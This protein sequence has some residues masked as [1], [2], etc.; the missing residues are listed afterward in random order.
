MHTLRICKIL[1]LA[2]TTWIFFIIFLDNHWDRVIEKQREAESLKDPKELIELSVK[3]L[4][5]EEVQRELKKIEVNNNEILKSH[6]YEKFNVQKRFE[7]IQKLIEINQELV[8]NQ[9]I[10]MLKI[11]SPSDSLIRVNNDGLVP[12]EIPAP[13]SEV[14]TTSALTS[15]AS[16]ETT[17]R[18]R[19]WQEIIT[20]IPQEVLNQLSLSSR[21]EN[22]QGVFISNPPLEIQQKIDNGWNAHQFNEF[23]SDIIS[24]N[25]SIPD[26]RSQYC[27]RQNYSY[28]L[29]KTSV[30]IIFHNEA[31][32]TLLR[33]VHSVL[34]RSPQHLIEEII[35]VDDA[36]TMCES[37]FMKI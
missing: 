9:S 13:P 12:Q 30:I 24:L 7:E 4:I 18:R 23:V 11:S 22:G 36:S 33:S 14:I 20:P 2:G 34:N 17:S 37:I 27:L 10:A 26:P 29:P 5:R 32:S 35:L 28:N 6:E 16:K 8:K 21:G 1:L 31:W 15:T 3:E 25:R 19:S